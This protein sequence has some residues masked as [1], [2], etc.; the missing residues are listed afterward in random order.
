MPNQ[1]FFNLPDEKREQIL[2]IA[3]DEFAENDYGH[4]SISRIVAR[5]G[6]AKGSFYQYFADKGDLYA[7]LLG[8]LAEAKTR[9]LSLDHPD[10]QHIGIFA[11]LRWTIEVG[12]VFTLTHPKLTQIGLR[13][14]NAGNFPKAFDTQVREATL[15]F[16]RQLVEVGK[17]Q[18]D[19]APEVDPE[20]A[21]VIFDAILNN[22]GH[23]I[24]E[25][26][27]PEEGVADQ[28]GR[29]FLERP[30]VK[31]LFAQTVGILEH[32]LGR[33]INESANQRISE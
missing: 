28:D 31:D 19:I 18:G 3:M 20:L 32:G 10:P 7:Y 27:T 1:T 5:A 11:Y 6:I 30:E 4:A 15:A 9:F 12:L 16:Y 24:L 23:F 17:Q 33:R 8:L 29:T 25:R 26:V 2:Q 21:A 14:I 22:V 13:A